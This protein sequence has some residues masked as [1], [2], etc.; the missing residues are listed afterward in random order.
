M[1]SIKT[2]LSKFRNRLISYSNND[3]LR[4]ES[5]C[6]IIAL[7]IFI[8]CVVFTGLSDHTKQ[9]TS[10]SEFLPEECK[11]VFIDSNWSEANKINKIQRIILK[12]YNNYQYQTAD[13]FETLKIEEMHSRCNS[14]YSLIKEI[15]TDEV[16]LKAFVERQELNQKIKHFEG[17]YKELKEVYETSLLETIANK[18]QEGFITISNAIQSQ[19]S[20]IEKLKSQKSN[21]E[22]QISKSELITRLSKMA[23]HD[24]SNFRE[25]IKS[26]Y[27]KFEFWYPLKEL[28]WQFVFMIPLFLILWLWNI[29]SIKN[30]RGIQIVI[31]THLLV[32][33]S[34]PILFKI[35]QT[36]LDLI[37]KHFF[38]TLFRLL[39]QIN[40]IAIWHYILI[41][42]AIILVLYILYILQNKLFLK[43]RIQ[44]KRIMKG[45]CFECGK[46]LPSNAKNC[47]FC[48]VD[49]FK[50]CEAC[51]FKTHVKTQYCMNCGTTQ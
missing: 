34:I 30:N 17:K 16:I 14:F 40:L 38:K 8:L 32:I 15:K 13:L 28:S 5:I 43:Q 11:N 36:V 3:P 25:D 10:P 20:E 27:K 35:I 12:D 24:R 29:R 33:A 23:I 48:G 22:T 44:T 37:P 19:S 21:L 7:D 42:I 39:E 51:S 9:L 31:S 46:G 47:P 50:E 45:Q 6:I 4:K 18:N 41:F 26:D 1:N 49:Q 2:K